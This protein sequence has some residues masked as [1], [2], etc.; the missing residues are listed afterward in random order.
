MEKNDDK[1][2]T[3]GLGRYVNASFQRKGQ[4]HADRFIIVLPHELVK[5]GLFPFKDMEMVIVKLEHGK[6]IVSKIE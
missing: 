6:L 3:L 5:G 1:S 4:K 2:K